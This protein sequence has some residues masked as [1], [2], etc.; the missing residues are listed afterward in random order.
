MTWYPLMSVKRIF[1]PQGLVEETMNIE[2]DQGI[3]VLAGGEPS[4]QAHSATL[5]VLCILLT[6]RS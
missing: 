6:A 3:G 5:V 1:Q 4:D 2:P